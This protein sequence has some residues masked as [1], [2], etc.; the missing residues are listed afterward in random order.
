M[1]RDKSVTI[2]VTTKCRKRG[3]NRVT[4]TCE[5]RASAARKGDDRVTNIVKG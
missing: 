1:W 2:R 4:T 5:G 3:N